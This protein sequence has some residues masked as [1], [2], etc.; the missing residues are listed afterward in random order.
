MRWI[1]IHKRDATGCNESLCAYL[2]L[3][4]GSILPDVEYIVMP[5]L[6]PYNDPEFSFV[7]EVVD[8]VTQVLEV[9]VH[10]ASGLSS[11]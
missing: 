5:V 8:F 10:V 4:P 6:R 1:S 3:F 2:G 9:R 11:E 7:G